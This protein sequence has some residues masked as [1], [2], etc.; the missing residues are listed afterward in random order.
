[1]AEETI[2]EEMTD[3]EQWKAVKSIG[4][5]GWIQDNFKP[6]HFFT[7]LVMVVIILATIQNF[8]VLKMVPTGSIL[9]GIMVL[10]ILMFSFEFF[11]NFVNIKGGKL[12]LFILYFLVIVAVLIVMTMMSSQFLPELYGKETMSMIGQTM[13]NIGGG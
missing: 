8:G 13:M 7:L 9:Q 10:V 2:F 4:S 3:L 1:M 6:A 11:M 12:K 5:W